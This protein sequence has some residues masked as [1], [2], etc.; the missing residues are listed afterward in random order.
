MTTPTSNVASFAK[1]GIP[2]VE[3]HVNR[4]NKQ[5]ADRR[6]GLV[7]AYGINAAQNASMKSESSQF[8][9]DRTFVA[10]VAYTNFVGDEFKNDPRNPLAKSG[11]AH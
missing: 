9:K 7:I 5:R 4:R 6:V 2:L 11:G 8:H 10:N 1:Y 3:V